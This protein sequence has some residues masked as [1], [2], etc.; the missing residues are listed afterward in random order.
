MIYTQVLAELIAAGV[1]GAALVDAMRRVEAAGNSSGTADNSGGK[2]PRAERIRAYDR[3]RKAA[4][5]NAG[6]PPETPVDVAPAP[7]A[8]AEIPAETTEG[9][10]IG[11]NLSNSLKQDSGKED[12]EI[13]HAREPDEVDGLVTAW[14]DLA[15]ELGLAQVARLTDARRKAAKKRLAEIGGLAAMVE[16]AWPKIRGSPGLQG[17]AGGSDWRANFDWLLQPSSF[18]KLIEGGYDNW[19]NGNNGKRTIKQSIIGGGEL[20][21]RIMEREGQANGGADLRLIPRLRESV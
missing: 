5:K 19:G 10:I 16:V 6:K 7:A 13:R 9:G 11:G 21:D 3:Q 12:S 18:T 2:D 8:P 14:N 4:K 1:Q 20:F 17:K 15:R